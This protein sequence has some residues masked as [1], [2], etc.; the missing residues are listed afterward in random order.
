MR[1]NPSAGTRQNN[2][3]VV[4]VC[5]GNRGPY[6]MRSILDLKRAGGFYG[7]WFTIA[8]MEY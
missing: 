8:R 5:I 1:Q 3:Q 7:R 6:V 2:S 4:G